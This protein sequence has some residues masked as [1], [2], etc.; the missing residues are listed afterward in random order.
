[1]LHIYTKPLQRKRRVPLLATPHAMVPASDNVFHVGCLVQAPGHLMAW[2]L[3]L[4]IS[5]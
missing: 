5:T 3:L 4:D 2:V 1:M